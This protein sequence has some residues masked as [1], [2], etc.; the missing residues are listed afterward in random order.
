MPGLPRHAVLELLD[1][2]HRSLGLFTATVD[3][4][5]GPGGLDGGVRSER[6]GLVGDLGVI[7]RRGGSCGV[8]FIRP[9]CVDH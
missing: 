7:N 4:V 8:E 2:I 5:A 3:R 1:G 6:V 9:R